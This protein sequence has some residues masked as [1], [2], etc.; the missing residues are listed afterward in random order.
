MILS[1]SDSEYSTE[2]IKDRYIVII[3]DKFYAKPLMEHLRK[4]IPYSNPFADH[5]LQN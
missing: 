5:D 1:G 4:T 2:Q 3:P